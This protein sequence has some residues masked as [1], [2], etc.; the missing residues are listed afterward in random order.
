MK[1]NFDRR[2][3]D[4]GHRKRRLRKFGGNDI[5]LFQYTPTPSNRFDPLT[6]I[7]IPLDMANSLVRFLA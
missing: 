1:L 5:D 2:Q 7:K 4:G 3:S 6:W